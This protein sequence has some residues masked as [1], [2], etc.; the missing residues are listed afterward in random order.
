[1]LKFKQVVFFVAAT[2]LCHAITA[3]STKPVM[4]QIP[5]FNGNSTWVDN[6]DKELNFQEVNPMRSVPHLAIAITLDL[7]CC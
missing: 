7:G 4:A 6:N 1:M 2:V 3:E 5:S